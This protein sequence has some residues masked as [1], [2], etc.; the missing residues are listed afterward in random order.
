MTRTP[1]MPPPALPGAIGSDHLI[2]TGCERPSLILLVARDLF[3][4]VDH[5]TH[6]KVDTFRLSL[7]RRD[8]GAEPS[9][10]IADLGDHGGANA[11]SIT[12]TT[13]AQIRSALGELPPGLDEDLSSAW[14]VILA[15]P[16]PS[17]SADASSESPAASSVDPSVTSALQGRA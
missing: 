13:R 10:Y 4:R 14:A 2:F 16:R 12:E 9:G 7:W 17:K 11:R 5:V 15:P 6:A 3:V 1:A 8:S